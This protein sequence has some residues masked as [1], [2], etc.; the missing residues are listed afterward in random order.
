MR[1]HGTCAILGCGEKTGVLAG[2]SA[3]A[4]EASRLLA[5]FA[6]ALMIIAGTPTLMA[7]ILAAVFAGPHWLDPFRGLLLYGAFGVTT[8]LCYGIARLTHVRVEVDSKSDF[9]P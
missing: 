9:Y 6:F 8:L 1:H 7:G 4:G 5:G 3:H 2:T